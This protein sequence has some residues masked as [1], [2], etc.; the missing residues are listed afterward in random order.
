MDFPLCGLSVT[1]NFL[2]ICLVVFDAEDLEISCIISILTY[3]SDAKM[4]IIWSTIKYREIFQV[5]N[6]DNY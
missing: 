1:T 5:F 3:V 4:H 6:I 2:S